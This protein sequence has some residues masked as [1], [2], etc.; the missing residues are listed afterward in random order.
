MFKTSIL[1]SKRG[2][3]VLGSGNNIVPMIHIND[4]CSIVE[5]IN[6]HKPK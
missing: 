3:D 6:A 1:D 4:L 2:L 5:Y